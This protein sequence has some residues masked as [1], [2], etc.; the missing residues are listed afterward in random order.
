MREMQD[1]DSDFGRLESESTTP[2]PGASS[3]TRPA[4]SAMAGFEGV[5]VS[6]RRKDHDCLVLAER[7]LWAGG[8]GTTGEFHGN[9]EFGKMP[10]TV[11]GGGGVRAPSICLSFGRRMA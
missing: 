11:C 8:D 4:R 10:S 1:L 5:V 2:P 7:K 6:A 3:G 9:V